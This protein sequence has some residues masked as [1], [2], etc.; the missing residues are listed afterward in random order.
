[1]LIFRS[2]H[3]FGPRKNH[4]FGEF[5]AVLSKFCFPF[6]I[7]RW[8]FYFW[9]RNFHLDD[10]IFQKLQR[11]KTKIQQKKRVFGQPAPAYH[12]L[13]AVE[14]NI[15]QVWYIF[16]RLFNV[17]FNFR[18]LLNNFSMANFL[19]R[20]ST[21]MELCKKFLKMVFLPSLWPNSKFPRVRKNIIFHLSFLITW[22]LT[23]L[24]IFYCYFSCFYR[25]HR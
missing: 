23:L 5:Y 16:L 21:W 15:L 19:Y 8:V 25:G 7:W 13:G 2:G 12:E 6:T 24:R 11:E 9:Q 1:M 18:S 14:K 3:L 17:L 10:L 20:L 22:F 4:L